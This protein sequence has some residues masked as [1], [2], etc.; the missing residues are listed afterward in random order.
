MKIRLKSPNFLFPHDTVQNFYTPLPTP[1]R[2]VNDFPTVN[3][4]VNTELAIARYHARGWAYRFGANEALSHALAGLLK[5]A[6]NW[7][8]EKCN[9]FAP[10]AHAVLKFHMVDAWRH[11]NIVRSGGLGKHGTSGISHISID[12]WTEAGYDDRHGDSRADWMIDRFIDARTPR[13]AMESSDEHAAVR[14]LVECLPE[15][16]RQFVVLHFGLEGEPVT[17]D[18]IAAEMKLTPSRVC[19]IMHEA[20]GGLR[21]S[22]RRRSK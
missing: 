20:L 17:Q 12:A 16:Q 9:I 8:A 7:D 14:E 3:R 1:C 11:A 15:R 19:Q 6:E 5:A 4:L 21:K 13:E 10:Y 2:E 22:H 18:A